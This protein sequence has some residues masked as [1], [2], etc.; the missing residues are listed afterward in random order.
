[1]KKKKAPVLS[2]E[3]SAY[4][5]LNQSK[6]EIHEWIAFILLLIMALQPLQGITSIAYTN[7]EV[8]DLFEGRA[9]LIRAIGYA[10]LLNALVFY[11]RRIYTEGAGILKDT[12]LSRPWNSLFLLLLIW[13]FICVGQAQEHEVAISGD[14]VRFE[15]ILS[16]I[17]YAGF[18]SG[19]TLIKNSDHKRT[20]FLTMGIAATVLGALSLWCYYNPSPVFLSYMD[21]NVI[22]GLSGTFVNTNH[23]GY[24][25]CTMSTVLFSLAVLSEKKWLKAVFALMGLFQFVVL[26]INNT[27]GSV[28]ASILG[29]CAL[30]ILFALRKG[31]RVKAISLCTLALVVVCVVSFMVFCVQKPETNQLTTDVAAMVKD[32]GG[33]LRG[34]GDDAAGSA[35]LGI[36]RA[37]VKLI[38]DHPW[39]G[40]GT[41]N[42][43]YAVEPYYGIPKMPHNEYLAMGVNL[44]IPGLLLYVSALLSLLIFRIRKL[45]QMMDVTLCAFC[46]AFTYAASAFFGVSLCTM[47][48]FFYIFLAFFSDDAG[49]YT[50]GGSAMQKGSS[51]VKKRERKN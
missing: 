44:G 8:I 19:A 10:S 41:D 28:I 33:I 36:W 3:L 5:K 16:Y 17:A 38:Q 7:N 4:I 48:P 13:S 22:A 15:G 29:L 9:T 37:D 11:L 35:R 12:F 46:C 26:L 42:A 49:L 39:M 24:Y 32:A 1:M 47:L 14:P 31:G 6:T 30:L 25:L 51:K 43:Y 20:L 23:Y 27:M 40:C 34:E 50:E 21:V 2:N 18:F 45:W